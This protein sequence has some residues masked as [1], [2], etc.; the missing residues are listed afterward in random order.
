MKRMNI[1][2]AGNSFAGFTAAIE[3]KRLV[4]YDHEVIVIGKSPYFV[5]VPSLIWYP[6]G[7]RKEDDIMFD[8]RGPMSRMDIKFI[9]AEI[10]R[11][12]PFE[13][14]VWLHEEYLPYD[15]LVIATGF[16]P[17][18]ESVPGSGPG[19]FS[20]C[21]SDL[22][23]AREARRA[24]SEYV[25]KG[26]P[27]VIGNAPN[28][29]NYAAGYEF[30]FNV[31]YQLAKESNLK[32]STVNFVTSE[33][34]LGHLGIGGG[35]RFRETAE[36]LLENYSIPFDVDTAITEVLPEKVV[37][38]NGKV[39]ESKFTMIVPG[40]VG[41][42]A[43]RNSQSVGNERGFIE[44]NDEYRH[45]EFPEIY[46]AGIAV[47]IENPDDAEPG[48]SLP[49]TSYPTEMMARTA[50]WNIFADIF[51]KEKMSLPFSDINAY[52]AIDAEN[53]GTMLIGAH[54]L[55]PRGFDVIIPGPQAH[56]AK[57]A[58][59]RYFMLSRSMGII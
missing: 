49:R 44:T 38:E 56:W 11:F 16:K 47:Q 31:R 39:I 15:Y 5:F 6:F 58:H 41:S 21:I 32:D 9:E 20:H 8:V 48:C 45:H 33:P 51:G 53:Q 52:E 40:V 28:A 10:V 17:D 4:G 43:V 3:L 12:D 22:D 18:F 46:A 29:A 19:K 25:K 34:Y 26:G 36:K 37:L 1:V 30:L 50:A 13:K 42:D 27:M 24:W 35:M 2:V 59:E 55:S 14:Q 23:C 7:L 57:I 54:M